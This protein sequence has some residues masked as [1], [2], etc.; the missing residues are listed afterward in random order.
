MP[1]RSRAWDP[2]LCLVWVGLIFV[3]MY[4]G[5]A[6][7]PWFQGARGTW[8]MLLLALAGVGFAA[9]VGWRI[10]SLA[11]AQRAGRG[12]GAVLC[13]IGLGLLA[14]WQPLLIERTHLLLYGVLGILAWRAAGHWKGGA[15]RL[16]WA[17]ACCALVGLADEVAQYFHP[18]RV[19][20]L[21]DVLTNALSAWLAIA[22]LS[23]LSPREE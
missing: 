20:D 4:Y 23:L 22:A 18:Q 14:W 13:L 15:A 21:R 11:P 3:G 6:L 17:G 2:A 1:A 19:F 10:R 12:L 9:W 7:G 16:I 5:R 8:A